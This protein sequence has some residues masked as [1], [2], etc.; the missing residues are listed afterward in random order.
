MS[1]YKHIWETQKVNKI[2]RGVWSRNTLKFINIKEWL[3]T[4]ARRGNKSGKRQNKLKELTER[5]WGKS[6]EQCWAIYQCCVRIS[7]GP[8][9]TKGYGR[10]P[11]KTENLINWLPARVHWE[12][13]V[14]VNC[15][16]KCGRQARSMAV[17][18]MQYKPTRVCALHGSV[19]RELSTLTN[20]ISNHVISTNHSQRWPVYKG[21]STYD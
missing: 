5:N 2:N 4:C 20:Y 6:T 10:K 12:W 18:V 15:E 9:W 21:K 11:A 7:Q 19:R 16:W 8:V 13:L 17:V 3:Q 1:A 14:V